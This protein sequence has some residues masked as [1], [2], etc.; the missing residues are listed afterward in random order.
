MV[1]CCYGLNVADRCLYAPYGCSWHRFHS[2]T[3]VRVFVNLAHPG[4]FALSHHDASCLLCE[5]ITVASRSLFL[6][7][8]S[9]SNCHSPEYH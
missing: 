3:I 7:E 5:S 6:P 4:H 2:S 1:I 8:I 9:I